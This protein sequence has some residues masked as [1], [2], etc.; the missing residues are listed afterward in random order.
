MYAFCIHTSSCSNT[1]A[2]SSVADCERLIL[3]SWCCI[4]ASRL[5]L[6]LLEDWDGAMFKTPNH[7]RYFSSLYL[8]Y[9]IFV[10]YV[11]TIYIYIHIIVWL[12]MSIYIDGRIYMHRFEYASICLYTQHVLTFYIY[13]YIYIYTY[14]YIYVYI[15][16]ACILWHLWNLEC[17]NLLNCVCVCFLF[18][19]N[20]CINW[21]YARGSTWRSLTAMMKEQNEVTATGKKLP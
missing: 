15:H 16:F 13:I 14:I 1:I 5:Q 8:L 9:V 10:A 21:L 11:Y 3:S 17:M 12:S 7:L 6:V 2:D 18:S 20:Q 4:S 19:S